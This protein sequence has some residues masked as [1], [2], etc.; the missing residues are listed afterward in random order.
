[1]LIVNSINGKLVIIVGLSSILL[2]FALGAWLYDSSV[3]GPE[4]REKVRSC[5]KDELIVTNII[6]T[7]EKKVY[8]KPGDDRYKVPYT[9][10][11]YMCTEQEA[12]DAGY[13][14][15]E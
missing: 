5:G 1:M 2:V 10:A 3:R 13:V 14:H 8:I 12:I 11:H 9:G 4:Y 6:P 15:W 7:T